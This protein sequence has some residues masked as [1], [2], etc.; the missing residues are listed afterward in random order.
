MQS[1]TRKTIAHIFIG[2]VNRLY[3]PIDRFSTTLRDPAH[4]TAYIAIIADDMYHE[5][6]AWNY[7][8]ALNF[9][10]RISIVATDRLLPNGIFN[11]EVASK[12]YGERQYKLL[13]RMIGLQF[14]GYE[15]SSDPTSLLFSPLMGIDDLDRM[16]TDNGTRIQELVTSVT[17]S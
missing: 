3:A 15:R 1:N 5:H 16:S 7:T 6:S 4:R 11:K 2:I 13:K 14:Y 12:I 10:N 17:S 9:S 8:L